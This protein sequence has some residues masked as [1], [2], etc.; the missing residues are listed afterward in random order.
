MLTTKEVA[1]KL[2]I[3]TGRISHMKKDGQITPVSKRGNSDLYDEKEI[4]KLMD[5]RNDQHVHQDLVESLLTIS[6]RNS[7]IKTLHQEIFELTAENKILTL[8]ASA[9]EGELKAHHRGV[10][11][12][13]DVYDKKLKASRKT[14]KILALANVIAI[15]VFTFLII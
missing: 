14:S 15:I 13:V 6:K 8:H 12:L 11:G 2:G 9:L 5:E 1:A 4:E 3:S 7:E 10:A